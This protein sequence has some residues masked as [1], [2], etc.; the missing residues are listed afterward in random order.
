MTLSSCFYMNLAILPVQY[1]KWALCVFQHCVSEVQVDL[2]SY[3]R[4]IIYDTES[5]FNIIMIGAKTRLKSEE[6]WINV[7]IKMEITLSKNMDKGE[8][9]TEHDCIEENKIIRLFWG[10]TLE[11]GCC[12]GEWI[13]GREV[14]NYQKW[15]FLK[16]KFS[17]DREWSAFGQMGILF[18]KGTE[19]KL[20]L[21]EKRQM[22]AWVCWDEPE[23]LW[24]ILT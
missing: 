9:K 20:W 23:R 22:Y 24:C 18:W 2:R 7:S 17:G 12:W 4:W 1:W 21:K 3:L 16:V 10:A 15:E 11:Q 6:N 5:S 19:T 8:W 14:W 13:W